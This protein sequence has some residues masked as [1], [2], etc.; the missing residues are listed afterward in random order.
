MSSIEEQTNGGA[1]YKSNLE[2]EVRQYENVT[3]EATASQFDI[4]THPAK[5]NTVLKINAGPGSGKTYTLVN[6]IAY[7]IK[8]HDV[9]PSEILVLSMSNRSVKSLQ[10][11]L[12]ATL[13]E[14]TCKEMSIN[15]FHSF[16]GSL[17][18]T[19]GEFYDSN[20]SKMRLM[21]DLSWRNFSS[22]FLGS[23]IHLKGKNIEGNLTA[24][25]LERLIS[26]IKSGLMSISDASK[27]FR[28]SEEYLLSLID[29]LNQ[30]GMIRYND[31]ITNAIDLMNQS[32]NL[33]NEAGDPQLIPQLTRYKV[34]VVDEFQDMYHQ[35]LSVVQAVMKYPSDGLKPNT[36]KH[37]TLAGD[38]NQSIYEFLGSKPELMAD[39]SRVIGNVE[40][41]QKLIKE[42]F[43]STQEIAQGST[44]VCLKLNGLFSEADANI[45]AIRGTGYPPIIRQHSSEHQEY[46]FIAQEIIRL[47]FELGGLLNFSD[48][49]I[50]TR[51]NKEIDEITKLLKNTYDIKCQKLAPSNE[52][53]KSKL[54]ILPDIINVLNNSSSSEFSLLCIL[55]ILDNKVGNKSRVGQLFN[56]SNTLKDNQKNTKPSNNPLETFLLDQLSPIAELSDMKT[57]A[58]KSR[59]KHSKKLLYSIYKV[60]DHEDTLNKLYKFLKQVKAER[61]MLHSNLDEYL[62]EKS[63]EEVSSYMPH[64]VLQSLVNTLNALGLIDYINEPEKPKKGKVS[65]SEADYKDVLLG[66]LKSFNSSLQNSYLNFKISSANSTQETLFLE[67]FLRTYN[68][69]VPI[70]SE[71]T[72]NIS[73]IHTA[74]GLE[75]PIV[76]VVG[77]T[78]FLGSRPYWESLLL[79]EAGDSSEPS[80]ARL[81]YVACTRARNLLYTGTT[82]KFEEL[83]KSVKN[84]FTNKLPIINQ[85]SKH[86]DNGDTINGRP[87]LKQLSLDLKRPYPESDKINEGLFLYNKLALGSKSHKTNISKDYKNKLYSKM[88]HIRHYHQSV[89]LA[90]TIPALKL[91]LM[92]IS[93]STYRNTLPLKT[94]TSVAR[95]S[96]QW[97]CRQS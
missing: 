16:C 21:D 42:S 67:Y 32:L 39:L 38:P 53:I 79:K 36:K 59:K 20:Y 31:L 7:L 92:F 54:H 70:S 18:D 8:H 44:A 90:C 97:L 17:I 3:I 80:K 58:S 77:T 27:N 41:E 15:T 22:L 51:S 40:V 81:F 65:Q 50:L 43:R 37:L 55:T 71:N 83:S 26:E 76:F 88:S 68:D 66:G 34:V 64:R 52:W 48:F 14:E 24:P 4:I 35:L 2:D 45:N 95:H 84:N 57:E 10:I 72:V 73:T 47:I 91:C 11:T 96:Y 19:Y 30:N 87:L 93:R 13:G 1:S 29:Y 85:E 74:K 69:E 5:P 61:T 63:N 46:R 62:S 86:D 94:V 60:P 82:K 89:D 49:V 9:K 6:R 33:T 12:S 75:F 56:L 78:S 23:R 28:I 25:T